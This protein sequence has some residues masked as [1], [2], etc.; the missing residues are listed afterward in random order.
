[1]H[2]RP[3]SERFWEKADKSAGPDGC[4]PWTGC[5]N[6]DGYGQIKV[7]GRMRKAHRVS[8][9][10]THG[11]PIPPGLEVD[12][13]S[14]HTRACVNP[15]CLRLTNHKQNLE[16][17]AGAQSN[18]RSGVRGVYWDKHRGRWR[19]E[20][21]HHGKQ[22]YVGLFAT[23]AAAEAAVTARRLELFTHSSMDGVAAPVQLELAFGG[24][25]AT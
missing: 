3:L 1:M 5:R 18:S 2:G 23:L 13:I 25:H 15:S 7:D 10:L 11:R 4:W 6:S 14:C 8:W 20:V 17:R 12:H 24:G 9:E 19:A 21:M 22:I 16:N